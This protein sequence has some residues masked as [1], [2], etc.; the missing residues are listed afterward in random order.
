MV[1]DIET[2]LHMLA[3]MYN[4]DGCG[5][6]EISPLIKSDNIDELF[7]DNL[8]YISAASAN[9]QNFLNKFHSTND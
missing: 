2:C 9:Y 8:E 3:D 1:P 5:F 7:E 6:D 4:F